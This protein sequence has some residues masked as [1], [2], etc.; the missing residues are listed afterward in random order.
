MLL[1]LRDTGAGIPAEE[2]S[3]VRR[4]FVRGRLARAGGTGLGLSIVSRIVS[5][6]GGALDLSS[7]WGSGTTVRVSLPMAQD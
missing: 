7:S 3:A 2:L 6:H 4:K 1:E 5:E